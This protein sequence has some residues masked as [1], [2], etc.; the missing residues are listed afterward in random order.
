[1]HEAAVF[2]VRRMRTEPVFLVWNFVV[3]RQ[4]ACTAVAPKNAAHRIQCTF[5]LYRLYPY[6]CSLN[7]LLLPSLFLKD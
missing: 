1:M 2:R 3:P 5:S 7:G 6:M 4:L